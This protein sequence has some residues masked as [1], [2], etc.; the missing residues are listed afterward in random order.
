MSLFDE[1]EQVDVEVETLTVFEAF[2]S[3][4]KLWMATLVSGML[5]YIAFTVQ[6]L[7]P[8][9]FDRV[10]FSFTTLILLGFTLTVVKHRWRS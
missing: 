9:N 2:L 10:L 7:T 6:D 8:S 3:A 1:T 5:A 4:W